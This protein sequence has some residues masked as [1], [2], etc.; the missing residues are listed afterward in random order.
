MQIFLYFILFFLPIL[1]CVRNN[2]VTAHKLISQRDKFNIYKTV[3]WFD[4]RD[5]LDTVY[6]DLQVH[7]KGDYKSILAEIKN[8]KQ[9]FNEKLSDSTAFEETIKKAGK[10]LEEALINKII[11]HW[12][13]TPWDFNGYTSKP[14]DGVVA[15]GYFV[16]TTMEHVG[17]NINR[18]KFAQN[19]GKVS[20]ESLQNPM[21]I[22]TCNDSVDLKVLEKRIKEALKSEGLYFIGLDCH[23][24]YL[25]YRKDK[26]FFI[27][28]SYCPPL[29]VVIEGAIRSEAFTS[30]G[31][32]FSAIST[33]MELIE[34]WI[35]NSEII[36][37]NN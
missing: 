13:G 23:V 16:S 3:A 20:G 14:N 30:S 21:T 31:Y 22:V 2:N 24:G 8:Q 15:C 18:Y 29:E 9:K 32:Y 37:N 36:Q 11:P 25:L 34:K 28:S 5:T 12:Y 17:F 1:S 26:L 33:N 7:P 19:Y 6:F 35:T 4:I 10:Y 27:H